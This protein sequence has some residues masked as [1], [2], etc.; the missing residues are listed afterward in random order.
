MAGHF[1]SH[2]PAGDVTASSKA[3]P[4]P[5]SW[6]YFCE[7]SLGH[8]R[9]KLLGHVFPQL[10]GKPF[11]DYSGDETVEPDM[12]TYMIMVMMILVLMLMMLMMIIV[13]M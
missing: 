12:Y 1:Q 10:F 2:A 13:L 5:A 6:N 7:Q 4:P 3:A 8:S 9:A 11:E